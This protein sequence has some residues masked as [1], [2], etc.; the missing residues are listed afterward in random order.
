MNGIRIKLVEQKTQ[1]NTDMKFTLLVGEKNP[2]ELFITTPQIRN[3]ITEHHLSE[4]QRIGHIEMTVQ[5]GPRTITVTRYYPT[6]N[7]N[8][9][10]TQRQINIP[11]IG[12]STLAELVIERWIKQKYPQHQIRDSAEQ[13]YERKEHLLKRGRDPQKPLKIENAHGL[14][15]KQVIA[16]HRKN[17]TKRMR[18]K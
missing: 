12:I 1:N 6:T 17:T 5:H 2:N 10:F 4:G 7:I 8:N 15:R 3:L 18:L 9:L 16:L 14:T 13:S 11:R